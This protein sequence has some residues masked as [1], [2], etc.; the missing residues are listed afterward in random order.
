MRKCAGTP[1]ETYPG[2]SFAS[3]IEADA[4]RVSSQLPV[5]QIIVAENFSLLTFEIRYRSACDKAYLRYTS[6]GEGVPDDSVWEGS[7]TAP[8][9]WN[10]RPRASSD[11]AQLAAKPNKAGAADREVAVELNC[12]A[13]TY[14]SAGPFQVILQVETEP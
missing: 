3:S 1:R 11:E 10:Q 8:F 13:A 2:I 12:S 5:R 4:C 14:A 9:R 6:L 7:F